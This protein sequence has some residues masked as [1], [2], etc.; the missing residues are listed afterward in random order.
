MCTSIRFTYTVLFLALNCL[1]DCVYLFVWPIVSTK[2]VELPYPSLLSLPV[3]TV[4][5]ASMSLIYVSSTE[6]ACCSVHDENSWC[7]NMSDARCL[8]VVALAWLLRWRCIGD[9]ASLIAMIY[10]IKILEIKLD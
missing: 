2:I 9:S 5:Y 10:D 7:N 4:Q 8:V 1:S 3:S 6:H